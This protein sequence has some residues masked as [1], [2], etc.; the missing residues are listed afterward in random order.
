MCGEEFSF[1]PRCWRCDQRLH[2]GHVCPGQTKVPKDVEHVGGCNARC[3]RPAG[4]H[5]LE[6]RVV[7]V[8]EAVW[9]DE[10]TA[11]EIELTARILR[12][13]DE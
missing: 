11:A 2:L 1:E 10:P 4:S 6:E 13:A 12:A 7:A 3:N 5:W 8:A 9:E